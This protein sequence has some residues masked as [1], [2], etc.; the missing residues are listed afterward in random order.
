M[1]QL[2]FKRNYN[3]RIVYLSPLVEKENNLKVKQTKQGEIFTRRIQHDFKSF[4]LYL[5]D[6]NKS[7]FYDKF[8]D[9]EFNLNKDT[10]YLVT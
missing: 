4:E 3:Q 2:N 7:Y 10:D 6:N 5:F 8:T 1:I 9:T